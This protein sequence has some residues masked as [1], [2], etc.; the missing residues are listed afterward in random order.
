MIALLWVFGAGLA[1]LRADVIPPWQKR[2]QH[3][4][5]FTNAKAVTKYVLYIFPRDWNRHP[6]GNISV[7]VPANGVVDI[8]Q[9][10]PT[11]VQQAKGIISF[12][13][14]T[15]TARPSFKDSRPL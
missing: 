8:N 7:R 6:P 12:L 3:T 10:N 5:R 11:A 2:I 1:G 9:L 4:V 14:T 13:S 15:I